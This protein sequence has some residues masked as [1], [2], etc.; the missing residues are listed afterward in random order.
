MINNKHL[1]G[2]IETYVTNLFETNLPEGMVYH[3]YNHTIEVVIEVKK[4]AQYYKLS[5]KDS[6]TIE[7]AA[8]FHDTGYAF[9]YNN[10]EEESIKVATRFLKKQEAEEKLIEDVSCLILSTKMSHTPNNLLEEILHD[11][12]MIN[13]GRKQFFNRSKLLRKEWELCIDTKLTDKEWNKKQLD[14]LTNNNFYTH[15]CQQNLSIGRTNNIEKQ[16][17]NIQ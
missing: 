9:T 15:F 10:H 12:D 17:Q 14:F 13:I 11:A 4:M 5:K 6:T 16:A 1:L 8:W 7:V 2:K 3:D